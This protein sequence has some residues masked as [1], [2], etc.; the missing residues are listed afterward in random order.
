MTAFWLAGG[1]YSCHFGKSKK[2]RNDYGKALSKLLK[3]DDY[4]TARVKAEAEAVD[5]ELEE[6]FK[7]VEA[8]KSPGG[9]TYG[10]RIKAGELP[11]SVEEE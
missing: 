5:K 2:N 9:Q 4:K 10:E 1:S 11:G 7:K 3:K 8:M 6:A